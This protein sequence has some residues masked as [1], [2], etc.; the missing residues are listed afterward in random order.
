[1]PKVQRDPLQSVSV[2]RGGAGYV[3]PGQNLAK[4][5]DNLLLTRDR[6]RRKP[7]AFFINFTRF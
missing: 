3:M 1:M 5:S 6:E 2:T 7:R 4:N